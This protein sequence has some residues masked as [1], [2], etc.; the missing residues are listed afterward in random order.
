MGACEIAGG[1]KQK[2]KKNLWPKG[3]TADL[4]QFTL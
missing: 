1:E 4:E 3:S 2:K